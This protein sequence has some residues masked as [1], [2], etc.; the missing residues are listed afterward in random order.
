MAIT[1][2]YYWNSLLAK[3]FLVLQV[4]QSGGL[5]QVLIQQSRRISQVYFIE[6][7]R[8][9]LAA[10]NS[11]ALLIIQRTGLLLMYII[12]INIEQLK[13]ESQFSYKVNLNRLGDLPCFQQQEQYLVRQS[14]VY[15]L[16]LLQLERS[17]TLYSLSADRYLKR[18][19]SRWS[20]VLVRQ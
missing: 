19:Q 15:L 20:L 18:R 6:I 12:L 5:I 10:Q 9:S 13:L 14:I 17:N 1:V 3:F 8:S 11:V 7:L 4:I 2:A 16:I